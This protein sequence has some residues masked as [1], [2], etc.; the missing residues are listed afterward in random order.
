MPIYEYCC[1]ACGQ[2]FEYM[3]SISEP[4]KT[5]CESCGGDLK[6]LVSATS[7]QLKGDGWYKDLYSS[8]KKKSDAGS[9]TSSDGSAKSGD[10]GDKKN[11]GGA[12]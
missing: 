2:R 1:V 7:F 4:P 8:P 9:A 5:T 12:S 11:K 6:K 10:K 3:Q